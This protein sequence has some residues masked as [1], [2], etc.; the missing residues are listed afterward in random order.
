MHRLRRPG[1]EGK[2][3]AIDMKER[4]QMRFSERFRVRPGK[5]VRLENWDPDDTAGFPDKDSVQARGEKYLKRLSELEYVLYAE[6]RRSVLVVLQAMDAGGKDGAIRHI[7]GP[8]NPQSSK[9]I[10]FKTPS[11]EELAHDFLWRVHHVAPRKG[12]IRIFNRSHYEDVLIA[13]VHNLVPQAVWSKRYD[14][15]NAF[16]KILAQNDTL[17]VKFYLH[18]S[19]D[20][21]LERFRARIEDPSKNWKLNPSDFEDRKRWD[22]YMRAYEAVLS[23][24]ST[25][26]APWYII[27]ANKKWFRNYAIAEILV[28]HL[29]SLHMKFPKPAVDLSKIKLE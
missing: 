27:P 25:P 24:C 22:D 7:T 13:R 10:S 26:Q 28:E 11:E 14:Q 17:V 5:R 6:N 20:E 12:E 19:K 1:D 23:R 3:H 21:Q 15:I 9:V 8:L 2:T 29:S 18:I 16:E 4:C